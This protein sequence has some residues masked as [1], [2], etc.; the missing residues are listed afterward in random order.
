MT[1]ATL[2]PWPTGR[3]SYADIE[4]R[5]GAD[6]AQ[7]LHRALVTG[8][9]LA[10]AVVDELHEH[11]GSARADLVRGIGHGL[12]TLENPM[13]ATAAL[14]E[15]TESS[16]ERADPELLD[17]GSLPHFGPRGSVHIISL[18]AGALV[19]VYQVPSISRV[20][21]ITGRLVDGAERRI[22]E[23]GAWQA[24]ALL[25]G[26]LRAG[27]PGYV[28]TL[29]VRLLHAQMRRLARSREYAEASLGAP[30]NQVDLVRTWLDF[31]LTS[32]QA[33]SLMGWGYSREDQASLYRCWRLIGSLLGIDPELLAGIE[34]N[35]AAVVLDELMEAVTG[36]PI[37]ESAELA[38]ATLD[39]MAD[40]LAETL[41]LPRW[42]NL[43]VLRSLTRRF[44]GAS[45]SD[46]LRV[47]R[48]PVADVVLAVLIAGNRL[49]WWILNR[50]PEALAAAR[51]KHLE[52]SRRFLRTGL[53]GAPTYREQGVQ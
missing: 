49:R 37:T 44:H 7:L 34:N 45:R 24:E 48:T 27:G 9:P 22:R 10:D 50:R 53:D 46:R 20:L 38:A 3:G 23:T 31:T 51:A 1:D 21:A 36:D 35:G 30:I 13:P 18:S 29:Q 11:G 47:P 25:P 42:V 5:F 33:E 52:G 12:A 39:A 15:Q 32:Y 16:V 28:A 40:L 26:A 4:R 19:R 2:A 14:L 17:R 43:A 41:R 6:R 8:D